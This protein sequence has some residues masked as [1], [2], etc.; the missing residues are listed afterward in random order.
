MDEIEHIWYVDEETWNWLQ[1]L[2]NEEPKI[3]P[4]LKEL[5]SRKS[6]FDAVGEEYRESEKEEERDE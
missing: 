6:V 1:D 4:N 2:L 3:L 5:M